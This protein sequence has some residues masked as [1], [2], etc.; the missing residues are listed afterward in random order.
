MD[1]RLLLNNNDKE[2]VNHSCNL[3]LSI[4]F[5]LKSSQE[6]CSCLFFFLETCKF[7]ALKFKC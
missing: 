5:E 2:W 4:V 7:F 1:M 6:V 3:G